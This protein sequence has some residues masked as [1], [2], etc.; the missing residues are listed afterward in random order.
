M[1]AC[2]FAAALLG[3]GSSTFA[4]EKTWDG[5]AGTANWHD[6]NNWSPD[7]IPG[8][9]D[10]VTIGAAFPEVVYTSTAGDRTVRTLTCDTVLRITSGTLRV[11]DGG[12]I[13]GRLTMTGG[14]ICAGMTAGASIA[15][16]G[17]ANSMTSATLVCGS[18]RV[19]AGASLSLANTTLAGT[20]T[21]DGV[22]T[23]PSNQNVTI[24]P[25]GAILN[26]GEWT[27]SAA[28]GQNCQFFGNCSGSPTSFTNEGTFRATGAGFKALNNSCSPIVFTSTGSV[29]ADE[30]ELRF[31]CNA[32]LSSG[33]TV[34]AGATLSNQAN[35]TFGDILAGDGAFVHAGGTT[36]FNAGIAQSVEFP[37]SAGGT[38]NINSAV[39]RPTLI[40]MNG[41]TIAGSGLLTLLASSN[42]ATSSTL[43][44][45]TT[46]AKSASLSLANS[47][48]SGEFTNDG[49][50]TMPSN[51]NV[52]IGAGGAILNRGEWT[53]S[54]ASG[55]NC[56][57]FGNCNNS[58]PVSFTNE[59]TL[60]AIG[61]R[62]SVV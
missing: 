2:V 25:S 58:I 9:T 48:V 55:Q 26:R 23:M 18:L 16:S 32:S 12:T 28:S 42:T 44:V 56:R 60:R 7:G 45:P 34:A 41:T 52:T 21:N 49:V 57:V 39:V 8:E 29:F 1:R 51:Q 40:A 4:A 3:V 27:M 31:N 53:M 20:L 46:V 37:S 24:G 33:A 59:G 22:V 38:V 19:A 61:D 54:A 6:A 17:E 50:V 36:S 10:T 30:G 35:L 14:G 47:T 43:A 15:L 5:G 62:K 13:A 11:T